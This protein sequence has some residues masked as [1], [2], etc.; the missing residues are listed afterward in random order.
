MYKRP[1]RPFIK[2]LQAKGK[3][4]EIQDD[5]DDKEMDINEITSFE[6]QICQKME[7]HICC[8]L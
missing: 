1:K 6:F 8:C 4:I 3:C 5:E 2:L 7:D